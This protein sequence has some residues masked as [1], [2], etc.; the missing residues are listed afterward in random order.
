MKLVRL[1]EFFRPTGRKDGYLCVI[2][3]KT[4]DVEFAIEGHGSKGV[5]SMIANSPDDQVMSA[6]RG[7]L[8][9]PSLEL[10][11]LNAGVVMPLFFLAD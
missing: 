9:K 3:M 8:T 4:G 10:I 11:E 6:G 1:K 2:N 5:L 7:K